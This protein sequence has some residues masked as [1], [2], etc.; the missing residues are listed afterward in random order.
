MEVKKEMRKSFRYLGLLSMLPLFTVALANTAFAGSEPL[1]EL[2]DTKPFIGGQAN[3]YLAVFKVYA[4]DDDLQEVYIIV[5]SDMDLIEKKI[6]GGSKADV[7][8]E[9]HISA[10]TYAVN[11]V[12]IKASDPTS[13]DGKLLSYKIRS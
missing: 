7:N 12:K 9:G 10:N 5:Q 3:E 8:N 6:E 11:P 1:V 2:V 4:G 13:I